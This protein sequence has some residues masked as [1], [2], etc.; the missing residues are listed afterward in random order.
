MRRWRGMRRRRRWSRVCRRR[1][2]RRGCRWRSRRCWRRSRRWWRRTVL[3]PY[4]L[5]LDI[6]SDRSRSMNRQL[7]M[8]SL[9]RFRSEPIIGKLLKRCRQIN[10]HSCVQISRS[11]SGIATDEHRS[12]VKFTTCPD[13]RMRNDGPCCC[14]VTF[15][16][17]AELDREH[18]WQMRLV[19]RR[20][21]DTV[22]PLAEL[23]R[24]IVAGRS[25]L[26]QCQ[27]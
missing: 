22:V 24:P 9:I 14:Q 2:W 21:V 3:N 5:V 27:A 20:E 17:S 7:H 23:D 26:C 10:I 6:R 25:R 18:A 15:I 12:G 19:L 13:G 1:W 16:V 4:R 11:T 8:P